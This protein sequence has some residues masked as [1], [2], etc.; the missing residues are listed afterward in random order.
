MSKILPRELMEQG[1]L[2]F[3][4]GRYDEAKMCWEKSANEGIA[5]S[6]FC[7]GLLCLREDRKNIVAARKW[8]E[9]AKQAGHKNAKCQL[10][11]L[12]K[13]ATCSEEID[14]LLCQST[15]FSREINKKIIEFG[16]YEW[17]V[18]GE[19]DNSYLCLS[20]YLI[21]IRKFH[22]TNQN[23]TW[24]NS[25]IRYWLNNDFYQS[26]NVQEKSLIKKVEIKNIDNPVYGTKAG[27]DTMDN[28][29]LLSYEELI[30]FFDIQV[31]ENKD[32]D[33]VSINQNA[34]CLVSYVKMRE[35]R[36][37]EA[38]EFYGIDY[39]L[40]QGQALGWW[41]RTPGACE[42]RIVRVNCYGAVRLH[43][44]E[45]DRCLVGIR[46]ALWMEERDAK[47]IVGSI[48]AGKAD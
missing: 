44:R 37:S 10:D 34:D 16:N 1:V 40:A 39:N 20:K 13:Y 12:E 29:F 45:V 31:N 8:F 48:S 41:L 7:L 17:Y 23:I 32:C 25:D 47:E 15:D 43:G 28:I 11:N 19:K 5:S 46:P 24:E 33:L 3:K 21:D 27:E 22:N 4:S 18:L 9:K 26:F 2:Y 36:I 42:N 30:E 6:M 35:N 14:K 38:S